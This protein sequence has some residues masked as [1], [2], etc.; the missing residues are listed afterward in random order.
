MIEL[1]SLVAE[2][3]S[4]SLS[5]LDLLRLQREIA[6]WRY[7]LAETV[8]RL[9]RDAMQAEVDRKSLVAKAKLIARAQHTG[10]RLLSNDAATETAEQL[11]DVIRA[12]GDEIDAQAT[13][14][15]AKMKYNASGDVLASLQMRLANARDEAKNTARTTHS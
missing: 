1:D 15:A 4:D 8:A 6:A 14:E 5:P 9:S 12:R 11:P 2:T 7:T 10:P 3:R 13:Y